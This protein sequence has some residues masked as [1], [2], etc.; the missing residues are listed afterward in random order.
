MSK[1]HL[2][3][4]QRAVIALEWI[5]ASRKILESC[6]DFTSAYK[7]YKAS[8]EADHNVYSYGTFLS[9]CM[10][11][12]PPVLPKRAAKPAAEETKQ[13]EKTKG[14]LEWRV[15]QLETHAAELSERLLKME[16]SYSKV[17]R[18][19]S[20]I[21]EALAQIIVTFKR[22]DHVL[23]RSGVEEKDQEGL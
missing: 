21:V 4:R 11:M 20:R 10:E 9:L 16:D 3:S 1:R 19:S 17:N 15:V 2:M 13:V 6:D 5:E 23:E 18:A 8:L 12:D 7:V 22:G 14:L